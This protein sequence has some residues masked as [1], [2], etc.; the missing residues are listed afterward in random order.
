MLRKSVLSR[1]WDSEEEPSVQQLP[2]SQSGEEETER[3]KR[4]RAMLSNLGQWVV[5]VGMVAHRSGGEMQLDTFPVFRTWECS[6]AAQYNPEGYHP[7]EEDLRSRE[8]LKPL[9]EQLFTHN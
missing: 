4:R 1:S 3:G 7:Y 9:L 6:Q 5:D 2:D 8:R